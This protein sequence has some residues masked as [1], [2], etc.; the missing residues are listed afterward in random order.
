MNYSIAPLL[1]SLTFLAVPQAGNKD[2]DKFQGTWTLISAAG[3]P[4]PAC[5]TARNVN[6]MSN[7]AME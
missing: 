6:D 1:M 2:L 4:L 5:G 7:G 3:Q